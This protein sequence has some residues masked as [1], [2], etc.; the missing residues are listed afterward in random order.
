MSSRAELLPTRHTLLLND[1]LT[2]T[3][4]MCRDGDLSE[5][6]QTSNLMQCRLNERELEIKKLNNMD[7]HLRIRPHDL[8]VKL[9]AAQHHEVTL[10]ES[11]R[12][13]DSSQQ[14][15][16]SAHSQMASFRMENSRLSNVESLEQNCVHFITDDSAQ[17]D[18]SSWFLKP[19]VGSWLCSYP[20]CISDAYDI[21]D[22]AAANSMEEHSDATSN[23]HFTMGPHA[24]IWWLITSSF[25]MWHQC[26]VE[27]A[28]R[29]FLKQ[30]I[31]A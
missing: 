3:P 14:E 24:Y 22:I 10:L 25:A 26:C 1:L 15:L 8:E 28:Q 4:R 9:Q 2:D 12:K 23:L 19:S 17:Q 20:F 6:A 27:I 7:K 21:C 30:V 11:R 29:R 31:T 16:V 13:L 5:S 18:H